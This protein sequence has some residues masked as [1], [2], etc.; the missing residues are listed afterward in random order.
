MQKLAHIALLLAFGFPDWAIAQS[1]QPSPRIPEAQTSGQTKTDDNQQKPPTNQ[2]P[3]EESPIVTLRI[4]GPKPDTA[5]GPGQN[6]NN[7]ERN[8]TD[9]WMFG[10]TVGIGFIGLLQLAAFVVQA[11]YL[12]K[13]ATEMQN[14][15]FAAKKASDDQIAYGHQIER[16]YLSGG[17]GPQVVLA[18][19]GTQT[20]PGV[21]GGGTTKHLGIDQIPTGYFQLDINNHG[22]TR[23]EILEYGYGFWEADKLASLPPSPPYRW[24]YFK[25]Q[26]GPGTQSRPIKRVKIPKGK[27]VIFGRYGYRDIFG[28]LHSDG[29]IQDGGAP[30]SPPHASYIESDPDWDLPGIGNR[31]YEEEEPQT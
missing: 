10:A 29:F 2:N 1:Q 20:T 17:G 21:T 30:I 7:G 3:A 4:R 23:G 26:I 15:T 25:D 28:K 5:S 12:A 16:A 27:S 19:R 14:T 31:T 13:S 9:W 18:D 6:T 22:K 24:V 11:I 8:S